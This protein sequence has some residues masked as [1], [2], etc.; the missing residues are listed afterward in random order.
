[1]LAPVG[2]ALR[3]HGRIGNRGPRRRSEFFVAPT[4]SA[5]ANDGLS[6]E[7]AGSVSR[8]PGVPPAARL[9]VRPRLVQHPS[10]ERSQEH[11]DPSP[12]R[13]YPGARREQA[14]G[15]EA[16]SR[17]R[18]R[19]RGKGLHDPRHRDQQEDPPARSQSD[20]RAPETGGDERGA[21]DRERRPGGALGA[22][23][24]T[25]RSAAAYRNS[26]APERRTASR[27]APQAH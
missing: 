13:R 24:S 9:Q 3:I 14:R 15:G 19:A 7:K 4:P 12:L 8:N 10:P 6:Q 26:P 5:P 27:V 23:P 16:V 25:L 22:A 20:R 21:I 11:A 1:M 18:R 17:R 2:V